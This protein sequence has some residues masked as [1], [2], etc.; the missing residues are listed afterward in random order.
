[1]PNCPKLKDVLNIKD[2]YEDEDEYLK[3]EDTLYQIF[4]NEICDE[5]L[6]FNGKKIRLKYFPPHKDLDSAFYHLTSV[7]FEY[8]DN[9]DSREF[10]SDRSKRLHWIK[11]TIETNHIDECNKECIYIYPKIHRGKKTRTILFNKLD[12]YVI[13]LEERDDYYLL[14]TAYYLNYDNMVEKFDKEYKNYLK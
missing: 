11:P 14:V 9:E 5:N 7:N 2:D 10:D 6:K 1:M 13:I 4:L 12:K 3:V 8:R